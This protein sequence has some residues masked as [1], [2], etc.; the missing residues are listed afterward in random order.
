M[1]TKK[2]LKSNTK[3]GHYRRDVLTE[4]DVRCIKERLWYGESTVA[5]ARK[6]KC[7]ANTMVNIYT[8]HRWTSVPWPNRATGGMPKQR[9]DLIEQAR[10]IVHDQEV[11][12]IVR[13]FLRT[14][15]CAR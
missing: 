5:I 7:P 2:R 9:K 1:A 11:P 15:E 4:D 6:L 8:G 3:Y 12:K 13:E 10:K 14:R